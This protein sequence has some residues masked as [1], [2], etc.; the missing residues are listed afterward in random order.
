MVRAVISAI[1]V[2]AAA[3]EGPAQDGQLIPGMLTGLKVVA[4]FTAVGFAASI[5]SLFLRPR[6]PVQAEAEI[7]A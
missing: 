7:L 1:L 6:V 3:W 4:A 5:A 2:N